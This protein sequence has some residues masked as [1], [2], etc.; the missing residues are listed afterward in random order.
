[1]DDNTQILESLRLLLK[2]EF[3]TIDIVPK[4]SRIHEMLWRNTYDIILLDMNFAMGET[5]GNEGIFWLNEI[6]KTDPLLPVI[7]I[8][9]YGDIELAVKAI[10]EGATDFIT[11][12]WDPEKLIITLK[13]AYNLRKSGQEVKKLKDR[14][15]QLSE[16]LER[17][18]RMFQGSSEVMKGLLT[19]VSRVAATDANILILGE[20][21][22][23]KEVI[24]REIHRL[25][26]RSE[27]IFVGVDVASLSESLFES[28]MFG[29]VKGAF[30]DARDDRVGRFENAHEGSLFL[31]EIGNIPLPIQAK[32]LQ[33]IQNRELIRVG[34]HTPI[35]IDI[36]LITATNRPLKKMVSE[37]SFREDL[38]YR[39]NTV[40]IEVPPLRDRG[41]DIVILGKL[42]LE[43]Y[44]RKYN[45]PKL[46]LSNSALQKLRDYSWPGNVRELKHS[47]ERAVIMGESSRLGP[48]DLLLF[49]RNEPTGNHSFRLDDVER[50]TIVRVVDKCRGNHS[51]AAQMLDISR[52]TLYAKL[53]KYGI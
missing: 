9:A 40:A 49:D 38:Y 24:A 17:E 22:T 52:T 3:K 53:K 2:D 31:D 11:K 33:V 10:R 18:H 51:K 25:S 44:S 36:R 34:D 32:L 4:P 6:K 23:G 5:S 37:G 19:T 42:F 27:H 20:N 35:Q 21:G 16:D 14:Q 45:K 15:Q 28:E 48:D 41:E 30:T 43:Q 1:I 26:N 12:P 50:Q 47:M 8:T 7:L 39:L 46:K 29:H 13:N